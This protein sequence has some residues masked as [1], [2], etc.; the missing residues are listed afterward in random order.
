MGGPAALRV[1]SAPRGSS[2]VGV[3]AVELLSGKELHVTHTAK[4]YVLA[5]GGIETPRLLLNSPQLCHLP[6]YEVIGQCFS[7]HPE[8]QRF[9]NV[10][11]ATDGPHAGLL[12]HAMGG[13]LAPFRWR[14]RPE[15]VRDEK[16]PNFECAKIDQEVLDDKELGEKGYHVNYLGHHLGA[17]RMSADPSTGVCDGQCK[18]HGVDN[19][20]V[21]G[22]SV[23]PS[24]GCADPTV[25]A[26]A[27]ALRLAQHLTREEG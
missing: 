17:T 24:A 9:A 20:F 23:F 2:I 11:L 6:M 13:T 25:T 5:L 3:E 4:E 10:Q 19:L 15:C 16:L 14:P 12:T 1:L 26:L 7:T 8:L 18:V 21:A 22:T 27:L